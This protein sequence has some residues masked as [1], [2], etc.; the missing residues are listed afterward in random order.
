MGMWELG[1]TQ[2]F[3]F[4]TATE[5]KNTGIEALKENSIKI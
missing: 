3:F 5:K 1:N 4:K 2:H